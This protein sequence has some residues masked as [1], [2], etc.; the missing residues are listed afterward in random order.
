M[1]TQ[2]TLAAALFNKVS[3]IPDRSL[4]RS[5]KVAL[6][7]TSLPAAIDG[8]PTL[9]TAIMYLFEAAAYVALLWKT[10]G[11]IALTAA[12]IVIGEYFIPVPLRFVC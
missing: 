12:M 11:P 2:G 4:V 7:T 10:L 1:S 5:A 3:S 9:Y 8:I 6:I